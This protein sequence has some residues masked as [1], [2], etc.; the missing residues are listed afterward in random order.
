MFDFAD[1]VRLFDDLFLPV[2][3]LAVQLI[4]PETVLAGGGTND[5]LVVDMQGDPVTV[6]QFLGQDRFVVPL[7]L[8]QVAVSVDDAVKADAVAPEEPADIPFRPEGGGVDPDLI[9]LDLEFP[10]QFRRS[11]PEPFTVKIP[12]P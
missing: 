1:P 4:R 8:L 9:P 5:F 3:V 12:C 10:D 6:R 7:D 2:I 11:E